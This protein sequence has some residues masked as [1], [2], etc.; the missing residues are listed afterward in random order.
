MEEKTRVDRSHTCVQ[1]VAC[2]RVRIVLPFGLGY[3][4][5]TRKAGAYQ[6][7]PVRPSAD[8]HRLQGHV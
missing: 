7:D 8:I 2:C 1:K 5:G 3:Y 4:R 6:D